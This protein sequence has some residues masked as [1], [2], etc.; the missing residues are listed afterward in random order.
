M[1]RFSGMKGLII[2]A[3]LACMVVGYYAYLSNR[4]VSEEEP[5][6]VDYKLMTDVQ[7]VIARDLETY[8][9]PSPREVVKY[10]SEITTCFYNDEYSEEELEQMAHKIRQ[11]YDDDLIANQTDEEYMKQ[12]K[13]DIAEYK[14]KERIISSFAPSSSVDVETYSADGYEWAKLYCVYSIKETMIS[15]SNTEFLLRK[16]AEGHYK[17]FGWK[18]AKKDE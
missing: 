5:E 1:K 9:P 3:L 11:L 16:D 15:N 7:K 14:E 13:E 10:F 6:Q 18:L 12:L 4:Q 8:Y 17:I 2:L